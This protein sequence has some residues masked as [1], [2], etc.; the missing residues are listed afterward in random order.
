M[1][2]WVGGGQGC[3]WSSCFI[4]IKVNPILNIV[5]KFC[6]SESHSVMSDSLRPHGLYSPWNSAGQNAG[7]GNCYIV[8]QV[9]EYFGHLMW[10][11]THWKRLWC[12]ERLKAGEG[13][14]RG[15]DGWMASPTKW[16]WVWASSRSWWWTGRPVVLWF[17][18]R[19][20]S[21]TNEQLNWTENL[22]KEYSRWGS[23]F[24][25]STEHSEIGLGSF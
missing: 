3:E 10:R 13:D 2:S 6:E 7:V 5:V 18:G 22:L 16:T 21:D 17:M 23:I 20:E 25:I 14:N 24:W 12:W 19:K 11:L 1:D 15:W 8:T 9:S 4:R